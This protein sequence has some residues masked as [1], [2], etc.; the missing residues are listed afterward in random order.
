MNNITS[1]SKKIE[2][3]YSKEDLNQ[4]FDRALNKTLGEIDNLG[5]LSHAQDYN[6]QKG[7]AGTIVEQCILQYPPDRE[8]KPDLVII[9]GNKRIPTELK[10]TGMRVSNG[11]KQHYV[12]KEPMSITAV[13]V[14]D[15][16]DQSFYDS[17]FWAKIQHL[18]LVYYLYEADKPVPPSEYAPFPIKGYEYWDCN[19]EDEATFKEDWTYVHD[20]CAQ[21]VENHPGPRNKQWREAIKQEYIDKHRDLR[22]VLSYVELVP[23]FPPRF[24]LKKGIVNSIISNHFQHDLEQLPGRYTTVSDIDTKCRELEERYS[25]L[26]IGELADTFGVPK[27]TEG[28]SE[29]KGIAEQIV[30]RMFGGHSRKLNNVD[31][32]N[33]FGLTAKT[34]TMTPSGG[35]TEDMKLYHIDFEEMIKKEYVDEDGT[36][37]PFEFEDSEMYYYFSSNEFLCIVFEEPAKEYSYDYSTNQEKEVKHLLV[38]NTFIGFK[39]VVFSDSFIEEKVRKCW[40]DTRGKILE[41]RLVDV[42]QKNKNGSVR[43]VGSGDVSSAPNFMKSSENTVFLRGSGEDSSLEHKT[44]MVNGIRMLPQYLWIKGTAIV[45]EVGYMATNYHNDKSCLIAADDTPLYKN[46]NTPKSGNQ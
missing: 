32:F 20:L 30:V 39:R 1:P 38:E 33:R 9:D 14:Y 18:L 27:T 15:I 2:H 6:L 41:N 17:H 12:A 45:E 31:L 13:G 16:A 22:R 35:R 3:E 37:R 46:V 21:I 10:T 40:E 43:Y 36:T 26:S 11:G 28:G 42:V 8:Q 29:N 24:R 34:I 7:I 5:I 25:G 44:E 4:R 23:K 19:K